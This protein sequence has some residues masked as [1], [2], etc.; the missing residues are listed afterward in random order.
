MSTLIIDHRDVRLDYEQQCLIIRQPDLPPRSV[1]LQGLQRI[2]CLHGVQLSSTVLGQCQ[3]HAVDF[4]QV[5]SRHSDL[6]FA[7][8]ARH[9]HQALRRLVQYRLSQ[10]AS[11]TL[12]LSQLLVSAK[13]GQALVCLRRED[14][15][16]L[17][18]QSRS[19]LCRLRSRL[20][21]ANTADQLRGL[22]GLAQRGLFEYW[23]GQLS[24]D[25]GFTQRQRRP[26]PD[27]VNAL[28]SLSFTLMYHEAIRQCLIHGLDSWLGVYHQP[29]HGR[30]S[31]ACDLMEPL[32]PHIEAWVVQRFRSGDFDRRQFSQSAGGCQLGKQ[33]RE[34]Y[35]ALWHQQLPGWSAR[36]GRYAAWLARFLNH[37]GKEPEDAACT[38]V[39][40]QL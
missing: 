3:R 4:I 9:Q 39:P 22:E 27:P 30:H 19:E 15:S 23:K 17:N 14:D 8:H 34:H 13:L 24:P 28:L 33:G 5:N 20:K 1:P 18:L 21:S 31:L 29:A 16:P 35:Y 2:V 37:T 6:S 38:L 36:L 12:R 25:L 10:S 7:L 11:A 26:P 32:R 40:D